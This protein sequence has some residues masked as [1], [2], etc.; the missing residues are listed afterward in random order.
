M[1]TQ[2]SPIRPKG[3]GKT[4]KRHDL[5]GTPGLRGDLQYGDV[6]KLEAGQR[7]VQATAYR[8]P[9]GGGAVANPASAPV[10][11]PADPI[12][13]AV[14]KIGGGTVQPPTGAISQLDPSKMAPLIARLAASNVSPIIK[15]AYIQFVQSIN[16]QPV[17]GAGTVYLDR[18]AYDR[19]ANEAF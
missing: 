8:Q 15:K 4:A 19:A 18:Q 2:N 17:S 9:Q 7:A 3:V 16:Q 10:V 14:S 6:Q 13:F 1:A 11:P 12:S 5:D